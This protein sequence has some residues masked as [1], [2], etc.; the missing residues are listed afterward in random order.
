MEDDAQ[1]YLPSACAYDIFPRILYTYR[2]LRY[3]WEKLF[4][5]IERMYWNRV[6]MDGLYVGFPIE[7]VRLSLAQ[8]DAAPSSLLP[9]ISGGR[10]RPSGDVSF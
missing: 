3:R 10:L 4:A 8:L 6:Y 1:H 7:T 5:C 9:E 2:P